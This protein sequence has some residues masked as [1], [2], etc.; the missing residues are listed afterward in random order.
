MRIA[1]YRE[2]STGEA[3]Y[4]VVSGDMIH[5]IEGSPFD[6]RIRH[7][8]VGRP[9]AG[10][11]LLAP[12]TPQTIAAGG[13]NYRAHAREIGQPMP[14]VPVFF[15]K[16]AT[17]V[18]GPDSQIDYPEQ[19]RQLE[20]EG[21]LAVVVGRPMRRVAPKDVRAH[22]LGYT[23]V[24]D[25]TARD[26]QRWGGNFLHLCHSKSF[27]TFCPTGPWIETDLDPN[28]LELTLSVNGAVRQKT[29]TSDMIFN[30][31]EMVSYISHVMTL[32]PGDLVLTGTPSGVG[33]MQVGDTV[34]LTIEGI[35]TLRNTV[36]L[37]RA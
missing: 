4:G 6:D 12:C 16:P 34:E 19:T 21:E 25:I 10:V 33:A 30:V 32:M 9:L 24:N 5:D 36:G 15:I 27:D 37:P 8:D 17:T 11:T 31:E 2:G 29:G 13:L 22:V 7:S 26:I 28:N 3:R 23:C 20:Y 14:E 18:T 1:R 35:G